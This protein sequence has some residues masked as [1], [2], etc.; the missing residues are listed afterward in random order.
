[1]SAGSHSVGDIAVNSGVTLGIGGDHV[2]YLTTNNLSLD[3]AVRFNDS[4][5]LL[6]GALSGAGVLTFG[7]A[8]QAPQSFLTGLLIANGNPN[9]ISNSVQTDDTV[10][11]SAVVGVSAPATVTYNGTWNAAGASAQSSVVLRDGA[12]FVLGATAQVN[13]ATRP[14]TVIGKGA[15]INTFEIDPAFV[16]TGLGAL[17]V[18]DATLVTHSSTSL[19]PVLTFTP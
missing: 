14:F 10:A 2:N 1:M 3:G 11:G 7:A 5:L 19:P 8:T 12:K 17:S 15:A 9:T 13:T 16:P 4:A 18:R 6:K